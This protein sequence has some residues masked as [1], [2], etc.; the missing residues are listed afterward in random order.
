MGNC[1]GSSRFLQVQRIICIYDSYAKFIS[2]VVQIYLAVF[3]KL[4][5][6][7]CCV[8]RTRRVWNQTKQQNRM[9]HLPLSTTFFEKYSYRDSIKNVA[10][11]FL[12]EMRKGSHTSHKLTAKNTPHMDWLLFWR[13]NFIMNRFGSPERDYSLSNGDMM[14]DSLRSPTSSKRTSYNFC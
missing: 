3:G 6:T 11:I 9:P 8:T 13:S 1:S 10:W 4:C 14:H 7:A 12:H 2:P 5:L